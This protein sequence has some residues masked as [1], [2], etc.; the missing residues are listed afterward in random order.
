MNYADAVNAQNPQSFAAG[1]DM[2]QLDEPYL[3]ARAAEARK[4]AVKAINRAL[5]GVVRACTIVHLCFGYAHIVHERPSGYSFLPELDAVR[6]DIVSIEAAQPK[7]DLSILRELPSKRIMLGVIDL[8]DPGSRRPRS[9]PDASGAPCRCC[10]RSGCSSP[11]T[12]A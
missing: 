10:R 12:A 8:G 9:W 5:E 2:V 6:A 3:Q 1:V 4:Y 7:L 11:P